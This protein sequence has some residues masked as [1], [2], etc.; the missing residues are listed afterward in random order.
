MYDPLLARFASADSVVP[1]SASGAGGGA[2]TLGVDDSAQLAPLTVDFHEPGFVAAVNGENA[3]CAAK[4]FWFQ[5]SDKDQ[6]KAGSPWGPANP[7]ALNRYS[8]V[9]NNPLRYVDPSGHLGITW[10]DN[11]GFTLHL[12]HEEAIWLW[13]TV[14]GRTITAL[15]AAVSVA[16]LAALAFG[17]ATAGT[18]TTVVGGI[19][20]IP[21]LI[22]LGL[23]ELDRSYGGNG[24]D[25]T[26]DIQGNFKYAGAPTTTRQHGVYYDPFIGCIL[27]G[28]PCTPHRGTDPC[29][30]K[31]GICGDTGIPV[32]PKPP[33]P[34]ET[35]T[36]IRHR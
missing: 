20:G 21:I 17:A 3:F 23:D 28:G 11:G 9:L 6:Q 15:G 13:N 34:P 27:G 36:P 5:L 24:V 19:L 35:P 16:G 30:Y 26:F 33:K 1:G 7:Q 32:T 8:Y 25:L 22:G 4:G 29:V 12:T 31:P 18:V 14:S 10:H 2:A